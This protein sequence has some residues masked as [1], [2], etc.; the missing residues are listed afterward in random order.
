MAKSEFQGST[1]DCNH[2][3]GRPIWGLLGVREVGSGGGSGPKDVG[4]LTGWF[5]GYS[6]G[7]LGAPGEE[8]LCPEI[9]GGW[10]I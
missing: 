1:G 2:F 10:N 8:G 4:Q 7:T 3:I 6:G 9:C 5:S